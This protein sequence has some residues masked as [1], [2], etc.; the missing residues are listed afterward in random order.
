[1]A[2]AHSRTTTC[3]TGVHQLLPFLPTLTGQYKF[4]NIDPII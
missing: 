2:C 3:K 1:M 4:W